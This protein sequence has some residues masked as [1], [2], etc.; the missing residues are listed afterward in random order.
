MVQV[1][2]KVELL[3]CDVTNLKFNGLLEKADVVITNPPFGTKRNEGMDMKFVK[4]GLSLAPV[5][6]ALHK[7]STR[8]VRRFFF[9]HTKN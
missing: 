6:Y 2:D 1:G 3:Q 7:T 8:K 9:S 4:I 5:V